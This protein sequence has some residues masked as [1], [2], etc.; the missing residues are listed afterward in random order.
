MNIRFQKRERDPSLVNGLKVAYAPAKRKASQWRWYLILLIVCAPLLF[1]TFQLLS[2][3]LLVG[4]QGY[5]SLEKAS[6]NS[7]AGGVVQHLYPTVGQ[8]LKAGTQIAQLY[9]PEVASQLTLYRAELKQSASVLPQDAGRE[10]LLRRSL[11]LAQENWA[12]GENYLKQV[13]FLFDQ[14][15]ATVAELDLARERRN[16]ARMAYDQA[17]FELERQQA[18]AGDATDVRDGATDRARS[19]IQAHIEALEGEQARLAQVLPYDGR[20]LDI[21]AVEGQTLS[22]GT[23]I[24]LLGRTDKPFVVAYLP[25]KYARFAVRGQHATVKLP[26]G[27]TLAATVRD[28]ANLTKRLPADLSSPIGARDLMLLVNLDPDTPLSDIHWVD[29]MPVSVRFEWHL[30]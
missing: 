12:V 26:D 27:T 5:I 8:D 13:S 21:F 6:V 20:V 29:G 1:F 28:N 18:T 10:R 15:A 7:M 17:R 23:P 19:L 14:G 4:A 3:W 16:R 22:S 30:F 2:S 11:G 24:L 25:P 9:N